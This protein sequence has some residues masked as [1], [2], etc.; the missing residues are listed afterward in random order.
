MRD[1]RLSSAV[2]S[3]VKLIRGNVF[4]NIIVNFD[5]NAQQEEFI[6]GPLGFFFSMLFMP[7]S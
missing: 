5:H 7:F 6:E 3:F 4:I 1:I 2:V